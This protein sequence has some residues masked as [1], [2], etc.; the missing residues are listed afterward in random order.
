MFVVQLHVANC[1]VVLVDQVATDDVARCVDD[2]HLGLSCDDDV[3]LDEVHPRDLLAVHVETEQLLLL[4]NAQTQDVALNVAEGQDVLVP[5]DGDGGDLV[6]MVVEVVL[7]VEH[8]AHVAE[9][10][11]GAVPGGRGDGLAFGHVD[12]VDDG[13]V[14]GREGLGLAA[15]D[16]VEDVDV[17]VPRSDLEIARGVLR[18]P[19]R[20]SA[21]RWRSG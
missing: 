15:V 7:I 19:R 10:L 1:S 11:D 14:V 9:H 5:V 18:R 16:D 20:I 12:D 2:P 6:F 17:V 13:V 8:V 21:S 4:L 3:V